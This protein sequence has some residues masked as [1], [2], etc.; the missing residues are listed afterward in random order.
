[1]R[2]LEEETGSPESKLTPENFADLPR[3]VRGGVKFESVLAAYNIMK[4]IWDQ[5]PN[6]PIDSKQLVKWGALIPGRA[7]GRCI[8]SLKKLGVIH[9]KRGG[10][11]MLRGYVSPHKPAAA[12]GLSRTAAFK[13]EAPNN[14]GDSTDDDRRLQDHLVTDLTSRYLSGPPKCPSHHQLPVIYVAGFMPSLVETRVKGK[15]ASVD[16][17][18][19]AFWREHPTPLEAGCAYDPASVW[20]VRK[21]CPAPRLCQHLCAKEPHC[22]AFTFKDDAST[23]TLHRP[24]AERFETFEG[25]PWCGPSPR[26]PFRHQ[27]KESGA[28]VCTVSSK[29]H[30]RYPWPW[31]NEFGLESV[32]LRRWRSELLAC[33]SSR[34]AADADVVVLPSLYM[35]G[36]GITATN[37]WDEKQDFLSNIDRAKRHRVLWTKVR[38]KYARSKVLPSGQ[39]QTSYPIIVICYGYVFD[40]SWTM[41]MIYALNEQPKDF[42]DRV[43]IGVL[44]SHLHE[45]DAA[46]MTLGW[47][48]DGLA[49]PHRHSGPRVVTLPY[50]ISVSGVTEHFGQHLGADASGVNH[51]AKAGARGGW[52]TER[53]ILLLFYGSMDRGRK[54]NTGRQG[55]VNGVRVAVAKAI[56][57]ERE[58]LCTSDGCA[59]CTPGLEHECK[60]VFTQ[61]SE[62]RLWELPS[63]ATFC[64]EPAGDS[65]TR[66]H[67]FLAVVLGCVPVIFDGGDGS[68]LY[69]KHHPTFWP[70]RVTPPGTAA[71]KQAQ[72][73]GAIG[74]RLHL[75]RG[76]FR[77]L[78]QRIGLDYS[79]FCVVLNT[80]TEIER[81][82]LGGESFVARLRAL[83]HTSGRLQA[84]RRGL[85]AAAPAM[86]YSNSRVPDPGDAF[87]RFLALITS[88]WAASTHHAHGSRGE[89]ATHRG[90][91]GF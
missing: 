76:G 9:V 46:K 63:S 68:P 26:C 14:W 86:V 16:F 50:P 87:S 12:G 74:P 13:T 42:Q 44:E 59:V 28:D 73:G 71:P 40:A 5:N 24:Y 82:E 29:Q 15:G 90:R 78:K 47:G 53:P 69:S 43:I 60:R 85:A 52:A 81:V 21:G 3:H 20:H 79:D 38:M 30:K 19:E 56:K 77:S 54:T 22:G 7:E 88:A 51:E 35:H 2:R 32:L 91:R 49:P 11:I 55:H 25:S 57:G 89:N 4:L 65:L 67:F 31:F 17:F 70:W 75:G 23:C 58:S 37:P 36:S 72:P 84:L 41:G 45:D 48:P 61:A 39:T 34:C 18:S 64:V 33:R 1:M 62:Q 6:A 8:A 27:L 80:S 83:N 66:S 10:G